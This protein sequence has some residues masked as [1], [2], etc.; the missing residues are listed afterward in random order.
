[1]GR[2]VWAIHI[3]EMDFGVGVKVDLFHIC[4]LFELTEARQSDAP[5]CVNKSRPT[6]PSNVKKD[7]KSD[8]RT[9][10]NTLYGRMKFFD[11][12]VYI[13]IFILIPATF[14][15]MTG[16][17]DFSLINWAYR[18][19]H[20]RQ[21]TPLL[22]GRHWR[23]NQFVTWFTLCCFWLLFVWLFVTTGNC[24]GWMNLEMEE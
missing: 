9:S 7:G 5:A 4:T 11:A 14:R 19:Q 23:E 8:G 15:L 10:R 1:M 6:F 12:P 17:R 22:C 24:V 21:P 16:N 3:S 13:R 18:S 2:R 20:H